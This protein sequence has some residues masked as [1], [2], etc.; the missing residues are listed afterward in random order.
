MII[1]VLSTFEKKKKKR[2]IEKDKEHCRD[3]GPPFSTTFHRCK[4]SVYS[5]GILRKET[6][7]GFED[8][9]LTWGH[10]SVAVKKEKLPREFTSTHHTAYCPLGHGLDSRCQRQANSLLLIHSYSSILLQVQLY[11][12]HSYN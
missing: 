5:H 7:R 2:L 10:M 3:G 8:V 4:R 9:S 6:I 12:N 11:Y 1:F